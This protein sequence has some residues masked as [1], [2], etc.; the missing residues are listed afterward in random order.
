MNMSAENIEK[1]LS[2][3]YARSKNIDLNEIVSRT[4]SNVLDMKTIIKYI[5]KYKNRWDYLFVET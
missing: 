4:P 3:Q 1:T 2:E 5:K